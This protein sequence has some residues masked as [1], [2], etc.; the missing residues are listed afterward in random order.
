MPLLFQILHWIALMYITVSLPHGSVWLL[1]FFVPG[2]PVSL[3][4]DLAVDLGEGAVFVVE[5][6]PH[7]DVF[8]VNVLESEVVGAW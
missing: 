5:V 7:E 2:Q 3:D 8:V 1:D 4:D 6:Q